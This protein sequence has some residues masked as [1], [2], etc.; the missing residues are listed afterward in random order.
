MARRRLIFFD[1]DGTLIKYIPYVS[2]PQKVEL[3]PTV[4]ASL[5]RL[6][7]ANQLLF[8]HTN[9]SGVSRGY[10]KLDAALSCNK[11]CVE[12]LDLGDS[13]FLETC[14]A[15]EMP[16]D[17]SGYRKPSTKFAEQMLAKY[18]G[19]GKDVVYIGDSASDLLT[20]QSCG[21]LGVGVDT[22]DGTLR[23]SLLSKS[24]ESNFPVFDNM[25]K[26]TDYLLEGRIV[27]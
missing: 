2:D 9:Q 8:L 11:K 26:V 17:L 15:T 19:V 27:I 25:K 21:G 22:G 24:P 6:A 14:V 20:A 16:G 18:G 13:P 23:S 7:E 10:F 12:L 4:K 5:H 1:R 3:L